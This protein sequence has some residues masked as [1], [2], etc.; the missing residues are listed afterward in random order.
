[1]PLETMR[2]STLVLV[3]CLAVAGLPLGCLSLEGRPCASQADCVDGY[4]CSA[5]V[6]LAAETLQSCSGDADC[7]APQ[8]CLEQRCIEPDRVD[9]GQDDGGQDDGGTP[10]PGADGGGDDGGA[11]DGGPQLED[12]RPLLGTTS[13]DGIDVI[14]NFG[15]IAVTGGAN[16]GVLDVIAHI[17]Y[18]QALAPRLSEIVIDVDRNGVTSDVV[19]V[20][21]NAPAFERVQVDLD[22]RVPT[23]FSVDGVG[24]EQPFSITSVWG[25]IEIESF[26]SISLDDIEGAITATSITGDIVLHGRMTDDI[27]LTTGAGDLTVELPAD[28]AF[29]LSASYPFN[30]TCTI[31]GF[32]LTGANV[33]GTAQGIVGNFARAS[34]QDLTLDTAQ[35]TIILR[36]Y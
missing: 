2:H 19:V 35:G 4:L 13:T 11:M 1:M 30:G 34:M 10:E 25:G 7:Q 36:A 6:C 8:T 24:A 33:S 26:G 15:A 3:A 9:G 18:P 31:D 16:A 28:S 22:I 14:N 21:P 27:E 23:A 12:V 17:F 29:T 20:V 32:S 5:K